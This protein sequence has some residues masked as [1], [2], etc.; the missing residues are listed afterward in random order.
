MFKKIVYID[1]FKMNFERDLKF[2]LFF[3]SNNF[4]LGIICNSFKRIGKSIV[5][6]YSISI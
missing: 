6:F 5:I 4:N 3:F 2:M 1:I